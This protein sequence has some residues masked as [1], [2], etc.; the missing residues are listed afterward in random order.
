MKTNY[1]A[2][3][4]RG[5]KIV[6]EFNEKYTPNTP[7]FYA[8]IRGEDE[9]HSTRTRSEAWMLGHGEPVVKVDGATG[10]V[11]IEHL[12]MPDTAKYAELVQRVATAG[13]DGAD[14][15]PE[16][17]PFETP[18]TI[19]VKG[20]KIQL[21]AGARPGDV[22]DGY[23]TFDELYAHRC[24]LFVALM[25]AYPNR[26]YWSRKHSDGSSLDGWVLAAIRTR[27]GWA[28]YHLP[29]SEVPNIIMIREEEFGA[30]WDGHTSADVLERLLTL[31]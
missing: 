25:R 8:P 26:S 10:C 7:C 11:C 15:E 21:P 16:M 4:R 9:W 22:S 12:A 19:D 20:I 13:H 6:A 23:H 24:R 29:E 3:Q 14:D 1:A 17:V 5:E 28:T 31:G 2:A 18:A 30:E 27:A